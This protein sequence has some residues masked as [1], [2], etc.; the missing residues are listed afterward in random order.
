M[1]LTSQLKPVSEDNLCSSRRYSRFEAIDA[2]VS[3]SETP[4]PLALKLGV[5][6]G[7]PKSFFAERSLQRLSCTGKI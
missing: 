7:H 6:L 5:N 3:K 4:D 2:I 1:V